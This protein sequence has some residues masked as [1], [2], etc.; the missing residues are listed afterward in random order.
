MQKTITLTLDNLAKDYVGH[1]T[2]RARE[3]AIQELGRFIR[4][5]GRDRQ[6][7]EITPNDIAA[8]AQWAAPSGGEALKRLE[9]VKAFLT[10]LKKRGF[11]SEN[12]SPHLKV[13]K[14]SSKRQGVIPKGPRGPEHM[15]KEGFMKLQQEMEV[16]KRSRVSIA[17]ELSNAR[18]DKDFREN[19]PLDAAREHQ[20]QVEARIRELE[21]VLRSSI[22]VD[23][24][25]VH[26]I[27]GAKRAG[28]GSR[29][30]IRDLLGGDFLTYV[31]V[32]PSESSISNGK[33]SATSPTGK[34]IFERREGEEIAV[35]APMGTIRYRI[36]KIEN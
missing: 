4:W 22:I 11:T 29:V 27:G 16:L 28:V 5:S 3:P 6:I 36:E 18:A 9:P 32:N 8:Y 34:A 35:A 24:E 14:N 30:V 26:L 17:Q 12:L 20:G 19:A 10:Y 15:T 13:V 21:E 33:L 23:E 7:V 2:S 1:L 25:S 31:L